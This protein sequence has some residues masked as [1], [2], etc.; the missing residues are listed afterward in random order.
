MV[1]LLR[2]WR[3]E[4]R[5][6]LLSPELIAIDGRQIEVKFKRHNRA[7]R[8]IVRLDRKGGAV[9]VTVPPRASRKEALAFVDKSRAWI[10]ARLA[11][12]PQAVAFAPGVEI[13]LRGTLHVITHEPDRRGLVRI[14]ADPDRIIVPGDVAHLKR[15]LTDWL[16]REAKRDLLEASDHHARAIGVTFSKLSVRD[17]AS[18]WGSCTA[19]GSLSYSWRLVL[20]PSHVL[21][22]VAV[23]EV[24]HLKHMNHGMRFWR[25]V[26]AHCPHAGEARSWLR[27]HG[28][29]LHRYGG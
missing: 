22:Y 18:R 23:H 20:A 10:A 8:L 27:H 6:E 12:Q 1:S 13:M 25:L 28:A 26:L 29:S 24:A 17:Q 3:S 9:T 5:Q 4:R 16:K 7:R 14:A 2:R 11:R 19:D 21:D 15:R